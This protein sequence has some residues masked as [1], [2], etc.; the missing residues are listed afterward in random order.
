MYDYLLVGAGLFNAVFAHEAGK[1]G[2]RCLVLE[3]RNHIGGN[4]F[5]YDDK[6]IVVHKYGAHIFRTSDKWIWNYLQ[7]FAEFNNFINSPIA[8]YK[9]EI[10]NL[11]FNMNTFSKMWD[12]VYP[13][14]AKKIIE[15]QSREICNEPK[16]LEEHAIK[17]VGRDIYN[18][19][20]KGYTEKQWGKTC[21]ELPASIMRRI[22][23]RFTYDNNYFSDPYQGI[24]KGGYTNIFNV[25]FENCDIQLETD[26]MQNR[27]TMLTKAKRIIYS[28]TIDEYFDYT[29]GELEYRGLRFETESLPVDN[30][31]GVAVVN[32]TDINVPY[33]R[34]IEHKH[35]EFGN[36]PFT[37]ISKEYPM[38]WK[39]GMEPYYPIN[40]ENNNQKYNKYYELSK[41]EKNVFFGGRLGEYKYYDMQDTIKASLQLVNTLMD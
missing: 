22:P 1:R 39:I 18:K 13:S 15:E 14:E 23:L 26:F 24:P 41:R 9:D 40:D 27:E 4:C 33:T 35:F 12:I 17:L 32:Y 37:I 5:T 2:K 29:Y 8:I 6:G 19:L 34:I 31:Q 36:Q 10:Y 11:P 20:I 3:R 38:T 21:I 16:N 30:Y 7:Q 28:G 25:M